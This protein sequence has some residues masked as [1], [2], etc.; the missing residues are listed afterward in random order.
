[1]NIEFDMDLTDFY[2]INSWI[3]Q[4]DEDG[5]KYESF[6]LDYIWLHLIFWELVFLFWNLP[7]I[8]ELSIICANY[9]DRFLH[10]VSKNKPITKMKHENI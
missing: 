5:V 1:M 7:V 8:D 4:A 10:L 2:D 6:D 3:F 9:Y